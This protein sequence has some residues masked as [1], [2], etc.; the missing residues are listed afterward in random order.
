MTRPAC[1]RTASAT[2]TAESD[3]DVELL[4]RAAAQFLDSPRLPVGVEDGDVAFLLR[5]G[6]ALVAPTGDGLEGLRC[7]GENLGLSRAF[8]FTE[9]TLDQ[10]LGH[11]EDAPLAYGR[12]E[13][14]QEAQA[15]TFNGGNGRGL[16]QGAEGHLRITVLSERPIAE[17]LQRFELT[18]DRIECHR[19]VIYLSG[20]FWLLKL[21]TSQKAP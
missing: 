4:G 16:L 18:G 7:L 3:A 17:G 12:L 8:E 9:R 6:Y 13:I 21:S 14:G 19:T 20:G 5:L 1:T 2:A 11:D 15:F 10:A